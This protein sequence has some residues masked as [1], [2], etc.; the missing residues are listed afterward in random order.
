[1]VS[2]H[3]GDATDY[4]KEGAFPEFP[5]VLVLLFSFTPRESSNE[6]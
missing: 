6:S 3:E 5:G 1:M 4:Q 2:P